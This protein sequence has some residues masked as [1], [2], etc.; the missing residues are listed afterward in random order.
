M[1]MHYANMFL[2]HRYVDVIVAI[3]YSSQKNSLYVNSLTAARK[4][5]RDKSKARSSGKK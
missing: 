4:E 5:K 2:S 3:L 1:N